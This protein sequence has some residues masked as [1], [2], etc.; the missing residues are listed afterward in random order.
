MNRNKYYIIIGVI[1]IIAI[2]LYLLRGCDDKPAITEIPPLSYDAENAVELFL[3]DSL[4]DYITDNT[5]TGFGKYIEFSS[6]G[7]SEFSFNQERNSNWFKFTMDVDTALG[8]YIYPNDSSDDFDFLLYKAEGNFLEKLQNKSAK[9]VRSNMALNDAS[10]GEKTGLECNKYALHHEGTTSHTVLSKA[11]YVRKGETYYLV[12][13]NAKPVTQGF[14]ID[15]FGCEGGLG[16]YG[17]EVLAAAEEKVEHDTITEPEPEVKQQP[18]RNRKGNEEIYVVQEGNNLFRIAFIYGMTTAELMELNNLSDITIYPGQKLRVIRRELSQKQIDENIA[19]APKV[20]PPVAVAPKAQPQPNQEKPIKAPEPVEETPKEPVAQTPTKTE[21][22]TGKD[23]FE[24]IEGLMATPNLPKSGN[25]VPGSAQDVNQAKPD[26]VFYLYCNV[27]NPI[28]KEPMNGNITVVDLDPTGAPITPQSLNKAKN[29][30][31][32]QANKVTAVPLWKGSSRQKTLIAEFFPFRKQDFDLNLDN[33]V[34]DSTAGQVAVVDDTIIVNFNLQRPRKNDIVVAY[35]IFFYD[36]A[37][38]ML[39]KSKYELANLL[40]LLNENK[41]IRIKIHGHT[42]GK[43]VFKMIA[44][45]K[46]DLNFFAPSVKNKYY[47]G[48]AKLLSRK[49]AESIKYYLTHNRIAE[50]RMETEGHGGKETLYD[51]NGPLA[52]K[53]KR[54]EIEILED[55]SG[56]GPAADRK[57]K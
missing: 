1:A 44:L 52:Y 13:D 57:K 5:N 30:F 43:G 42:N 10:S 24:K 20:S 50:D 8:F 38:V 4:P 32:M 41:N 34:N 21:T 49:R 45:E 54:V 23:P 35:N 11:I 22:G 26:K 47:Y 15:F 17:D 53:N 18:K 46:G 9:P 12:I 56:S 27:V 16:D 55:G 3:G 36:D 2:I 6:E 25:A 33:I 48:D 19:K 31:V 51:I 39:P 14:K 40:A 7:D 37:S 29:V 28:T